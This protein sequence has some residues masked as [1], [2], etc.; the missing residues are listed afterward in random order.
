[1]KITWGGHATTLISIESHTIITDPNLLKRMFW[2][3]RHS[4]PGLE[5]TALD[6]VTDIIISHAHF[7][8]LDKTTLH[9]LPRKATAFVRGQ[10]S[11]IVQPIGFPTESMELWETYTTDDMK[12]TCLPVVHLPGRTIGDSKKYLPASFMIE[13]EGKTIYFAGDTAYGSHFKQ[14]AEKFPNIDVALMPIGAY[15]PRWMMQSTH[16]DPHEAL[17]AF[18]D[19]RAKEFVPI[20]WGTFRLSTEPLNDPPKVLLAAAEAA[21]LAD[22]MHILQSGESIT[23]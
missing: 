23:F 4:K 9:R 21:G 18:I 5:Q 3:K 16:V 13:C 1:M 22:R 12:V 19:L 6:A 8:H 7:D 17:Q 10:I 20:H 15:A 11:D 2:F 14:I